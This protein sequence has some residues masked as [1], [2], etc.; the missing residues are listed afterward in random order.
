[1]GKGVEGRGGEKLGG[2]EAGKT[3]VGSKIKINKDIN[4]FKKEIITCLLNPFMWF[5]T[6]VDLLCGTLPAF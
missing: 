5:T 1:M 6:F 2:G 4:P 3:L